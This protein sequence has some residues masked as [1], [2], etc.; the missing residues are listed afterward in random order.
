M[1]TAR[2]S[3]KDRFLRG[4]HLDRGADGDNREEVLDVLRYVIAQSVD[5]LLGGANASNEGFECFQWAAA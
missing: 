2:S 3:G 1:R 5:T 4:N